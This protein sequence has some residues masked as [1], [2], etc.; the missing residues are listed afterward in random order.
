[1]CLNILAYRSNLKVLNILVSILCL[2]NPNAVTSKKESISWD[3]ERTLHDIQNSNLGTRIKDIKIRN[4][5][6]MFFCKING[7]LFQIE[8]FRIETMLSIYS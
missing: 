8:K 6:D 1:M 7:S 2:R 4:Q 5:T 3:A